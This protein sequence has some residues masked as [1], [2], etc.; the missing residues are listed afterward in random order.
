MIMSEAEMVQIT[1]MSNSEQHY[2]FLQM[3]KTMVGNKM[4]I[5]GFF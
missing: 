3:I 5:L 1:Q 2:D 4:Q